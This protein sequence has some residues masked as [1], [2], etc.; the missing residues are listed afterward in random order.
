MWTA[1]F[2]QGGYS[3]LACP[4]KVMQWCIRW[5]TIANTCPTLACR[6]ASGTLHL[7]WHRGS[8]YGW[9]WFKYS[10]V[11]ILP[12]M[13]PCPLRR[14]DELLLNYRLS[15]SLIQSAIMCLRGH[16]STIHCSAGPFHIDLTW[17]EG[18]VWLSIKIISLIF[19]VFIFLIYAFP[20]ITSTLFTCSIKPYHWLKRTFALS[21]NFYTNENFFWDLCMGSIATKVCVRSV[22]SHT[23]Y[24][25]SIHCIYL[26][27]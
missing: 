16:R 1:K 9:Y 2:K 4:C 5:K 17:S 12:F 6:N 19:P 3:I 7:G 20:I 21:S 27:N 10:A 11:W 23:G 22:P 24:R 8:I 14:L 26:T 25:H 15:F 13:L 18:E